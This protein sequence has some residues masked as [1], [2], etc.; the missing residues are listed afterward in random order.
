M[1]WR[2]TTVTL[3]YVALACI[4]SWACDEEHPKDPSEI[5]VLIQKLEQAIE[6]KG[7][8]SD[9]P[10]GKPGTDGEAAKELGEL[11][12]QAAPAIPT[13]I[14]AIKEGDGLLPA[15]AG[16]A[17]G[18]IG[19]QAVP[20]LVEALSSK[21]HELQLQA[22]HALG[23]IGE[24]SRPAIPI[25]LKLA[26][27]D[28]EQLRSG[29]TESLSKIAAAKDEKVVESLIKLL[30][31]KANSVQ[32]AA[33]KGLGRLVPGSERVSSSLVATL[34]NKDVHS[35]VRSEAAQSLG[36]LKIVSDEAISALVEGLRSGDPNLQLGAAT[37][38]NHMGQ[39]AKPAA[40]ALSEFLKTPAKPPEGLSGENAFAWKL[41]HDVARK[42]AKAA[43]DR[44][45]EAS[46]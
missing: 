40:P 3:L 44:I 45:R 29:S 33:A 27:A 34:K 37:A 4:Q 35:D 5:K 22:I 46:E 15:Q 11:G 21:H 18:Q 19:K 13:L 26:H 16:F 17:L 24:D 12:P 25:L 1:S 31:D 6:G 36:R 41:I 32:S 14:R 28:D 10:G 2:Q 7:G 20:A 30:D 39:A 38:F 42:N 43:L 23:L 8:G 9:I